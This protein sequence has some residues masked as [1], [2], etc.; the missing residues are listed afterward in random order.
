MHIIETQAL[1]LRYN[2]MQIGVMLFSISRDAICKQTA[3]E[4]CISN[5]FEF[6]N[7]IVCF[8]N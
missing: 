2:Y 7:Y 3:I 4:D 5:I 6:K 8:I 1:Q